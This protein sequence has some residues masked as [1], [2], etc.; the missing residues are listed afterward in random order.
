[1]GARLVVLATTITM[2]LTISFVSYW[3]RNVLYHNNGDGTFTDVSEQAGVA[4]SEA[5]GA[6]AAVSLTMTRTVISICLWPTM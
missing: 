6:Q 4:G 2:A 5:G 3:G 1:M